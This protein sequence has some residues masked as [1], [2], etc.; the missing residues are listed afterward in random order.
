[1]SSQSQDDANACRQSTSRIGEGEQAYGQANKWERELREREMREIESLRKQLDE[2]T[3]HAK[4]AERA[5]QELTNQLEKLVNECKT[6]HIPKGAGIG[7]E[8]LQGT[9]DRLERENQRLKSDLDDARSHIFSL[10]PYRKDLT[11]HE[12]GT[13]SKHPSSQIG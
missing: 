6:K 5:V 2:A 11:P 9:V 12:V 7:D 4:Q 13:V 1:M 3:S 10:Q 8:A